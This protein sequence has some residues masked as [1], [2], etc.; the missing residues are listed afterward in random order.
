MGNH[1]SG[2]HM[3]DTGGL[4]LLIIFWGKICLA[5]LFFNT[6]RKSLDFHQIFEYCKGACRD[7]A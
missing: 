1:T 4:P 2:G 7:K 5:S 3:G 6:R